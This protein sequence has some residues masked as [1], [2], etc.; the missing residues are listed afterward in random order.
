VAGFASRRASTLPAADS[1]RPSRVVDWRVGTSSICLFFTV[2][3]VND[4]PLSRR[5]GKFAEQG[6]EQA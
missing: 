4:T 5:Y 1:V 6:L 3:L 2:A